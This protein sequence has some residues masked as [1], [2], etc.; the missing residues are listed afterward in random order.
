MVIFARPAQGNVTGRSYIFNLHQQQK[1]CIIAV[2]SRAIGLY[3][4]NR[5]GD[6]AGNSWLLAAVM[7]SVLVNGTAILIRHRFARGVGRVA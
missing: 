3:L 6:Q 4:V 5:L 7:I 1:F 2:F